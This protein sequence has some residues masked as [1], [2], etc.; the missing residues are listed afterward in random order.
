MNRSR[1]EPLKF[2]ENGFP[3]ARPICLK[4]IRPP[5][6]CVCSLCKPFEAHCNILILQHPHERKK[7]YSTAK[8]VLGSITNSKMI[9]GLEFEESFLKKTL[10][11]GNFY[12]LY[13]GK[14]AVDCET[15]AL[16]KNDTVVVLDGTWS[17]A[18]KILNRN[19]LLQQLPKISFNRDLR[20]EYKIR[21]QPKDKYLSTLES[22]GHLLKLNSSVSKSGPN[23]ESF[24]NYKQLFDVFNTMVETQ[25]GYF[26]RMRK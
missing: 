7:Y 10:S 4:C 13:P 1:S 24:E 8:L 20:S 6:H 23:A 12:L 21:K 25:L 16:T 9:R 11:G 15:F 26:P 3:V 22:I 19:P 2:D 18:G 14:D 5:S 17:E